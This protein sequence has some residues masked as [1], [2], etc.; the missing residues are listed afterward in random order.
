MTPLDATHQASFA[1]SPYT[2]YIIAA[3]SAAGIGFENNNL[4]GFQAT[5][6]PGAQAIIDTPSL[7]LGAAQTAVQAQLDSAFNAKFDLAAFIRA[8]TVTTVTAAGVGTF[9]ATITNNYRT[10][11]AAIAAAPTIAALTAININ[12]GWP[13]NP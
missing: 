7:W 2:S 3:I 4:Y 1:A 8:G 5:D 6:V 12:A 9:L 11:R 13:A 10:L